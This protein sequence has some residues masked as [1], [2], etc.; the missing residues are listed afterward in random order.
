MIFASIFAKPVAALVRDSKLWPS[1]GVVLVTSV[2]WAVGG[3]VR[4]HL[5]HRA[6]FAVLFRRSN[7]L[8]M[9]GIFHGLEHW[10]IVGV[11]SVIG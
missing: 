7:N 6:F 5:R 2:L 1:A 11:S 4:R 9:V 3:D 10:Y 8:W